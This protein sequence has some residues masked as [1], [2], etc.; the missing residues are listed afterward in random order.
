MGYALKQAAEL[1][2]VLGKAD[3]AGTFR[4]WAEARGKATHKTFYD[5]Q[6]RRY[7][8]GDQVTYILPLAAGVVPDALR[9]DVFAGFERTL[10]EK[11]K[12]HLATGLSGTYMM[13]QY[14][15]RVGRDDL[16]HLFA[17]KKTYPSWGHMIEQGATA[18]WEHWGGQR[19][20]IHNCFNSIASWFI[21]GLAGIRPDPG[22]PGF[23]NAVIR[24]AVLETLSHVASSHDT[25]YGTIHS[26][27]KR[28]GDTVTMNVRIPAN[29]T[30]TLHVPA[31]DVKGVTVNGRAADAAPHVDYLGTQ[32]GRV[33]LQV[34]SGGYEIV[35]R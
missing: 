32:D 20:R 25:A 34:E 23:K 24:P 22:R 10:K 8:S 31:G 35:S 13:V 16:I 27:W 28:H 5:P 18:T 2:D 3:D 30:A 29:T 15:Q 33:L 12:G 26:S 9:D 17:S 4:G 21:Q 1:A 11:N 6:G 7:G 14:L 19:S